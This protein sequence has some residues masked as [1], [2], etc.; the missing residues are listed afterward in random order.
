MYRD[1]VHTKASK[2]NENASKSEHKGQKRA[3]QAQAILGIIEKRRI[4]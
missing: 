4:K 1:N 2:Q 3:R